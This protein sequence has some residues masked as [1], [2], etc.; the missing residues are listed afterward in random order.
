VLSSTH[1]YKKNGESLMPDHYDKH[2]RRV[3]AANAV[4]HNPDLRKKVMLSAAQIYKDA[5]KLKG[6]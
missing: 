1:T 2:T 6:V 3:N 5:V 4:K